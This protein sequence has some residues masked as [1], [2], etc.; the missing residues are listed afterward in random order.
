[1]KEEFKFYQVPS[2]RKEITA[3][4]LDVDNYGMQI[5]EEAQERSREIANEQPDSQ[6]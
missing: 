1:M 6:S 4:H 3:E 2:N 5:A